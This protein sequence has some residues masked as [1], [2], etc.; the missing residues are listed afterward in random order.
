MYENRKFV[1]IPADKINQID[2]SQVHET[3]SETCRYSVD[4]TKTFVKYD[5][6]MPASVAVI[7]GIS[8]EYGYEEFLQ[9]LTTATWVDETQIGMQYGNII[10]S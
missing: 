7:E 4:K 5:G 10:Q 3:S 6:D 1:I 2:F 9:E 8:R